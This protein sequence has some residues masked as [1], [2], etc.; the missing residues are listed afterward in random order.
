MGC[1]FVRGQ[2]LPD[3][4]LKEHP[5]MEYYKTRKLDPKNNKE[6]DALIRSYFGGKE[7]DTISG[8]QCQT[9]RWHK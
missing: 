2:E 5:Q 7:G 4:L 3:G 9:M 8:L 6:D 1:W